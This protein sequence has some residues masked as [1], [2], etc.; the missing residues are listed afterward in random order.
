MIVIY[1]P[2]ILFEIAV[3]G[4][5]SFGVTKVAPTLSKSADT[6]FFVGFLVALDLLYRYWRI[7]QKV[8]PLSRSDAPITPIEPPA[9]WSWLVSLKGAHFLFVPGWVIGVLMG[10]FS[11]IV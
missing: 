1:N 9:D 6:L 4:G 8:R 2:L 7:H 11:S 10:V 5:L 3:A